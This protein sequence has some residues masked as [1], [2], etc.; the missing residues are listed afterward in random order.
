[1]TLTARQVVDLVFDEE[2]YVR[3]VSPNSLPENVEVKMITIPRFSFTAFRLSYASPIELSLCSKVSLL[4]GIPTQWYHEQ[5]SGLW[6]A[7]SKIG[8]RSLQKNTKKLTNDGYRSIYRRRPGKLNLRSHGVDKLSISERSTTTRSKSN[9]FEQVSNQDE[10]LSNATGKIKK[11]TSQGR[12]RIRKFLQKRSNTLAAI[13]SIASRESPISVE[14]VRRRR[15]MR[16]GHTVAFLP[17]NSTQ[18]STSQED[19]NT[20]RDSSQGMEELRRPTSELKVAEDSHEGKQQSCY[21]HEEIRSSN[22]PTNGE[23]SSGEDVS[24]SSGSDAAP[25]CDDSHSDNGSLESIQE[26]IPSSEARI[27]N[28]D[29][30]DYYNYSRLRSPQL[31]SSQSDSSQEVVTTDKTSTSETTPVYFGKSAVSESNAAKNP[32]VRFELQNHVAR[33]S[34][35]STDPHDNLL[36]SS[37]RKLPIV[38]LKTTSTSC[39]AEHMQILEPEPEP[40]QIE[41]YERDGHTRVLSTERRAVKIVSDVSGTALGKLRTGVA[42][43]LGIDYSVPTPLPKR[44][45]C[46]RIIMME[47]MLVMV[48]SAVNH[49]DPV[50]NF[51]VSES[52]D[53]RISERWKEYIVVARS[54]GRTDPPILLQFYHNRRIPKILKQD[55][56]KTAV[57]QNPLDFYIDKNCL[58]GLYSTLDKTIYIQKPDDKRYNIQDEGIDSYENNSGS[59]KIYILR[60]RTLCS[61]GKWH[62]FLQESLGM[63]TIPEKVSLRVPEADLSLNVTLAKDLIDELFSLEEKESENL[64]VCILPRGYRVFQYPLIRYITVAVFEELKRAGLMEVLKRWEKANIILGCDFKHYDMIQWCPGHRSNLLRGTYALF[65]SHLL[66][67]RPYVH[68]PREVTN[69]DGGTLVEP[70][71]VEG[72]LIRLTDRYGKEK[73]A[74][75]KYCLK[76]SYFF[77]SDN[78]LF[79]MAS[80]KATPPLPLEVLFDDATCR[81]DIEEAN[82]ILKSLPEVYEQDPYP[83]DLNS[84]IKWLNDKLGDSEFDSKDLYAFKCFNRRIVQILKS[85]GLLDMNLIKE[86]YQGKLTDTQGCEIKYQVFS[87]AK[88]TFWQMGNETIDDTAASV[89]FIVTISGLILK[90]LAPNPTVCKEWVF[91]LRQLV[92][93]WKAKQLADTQKMWHLKIQNLMNLKISEEEESNISENSPKWLTDRGVTNPTIYNVNAISVLRPL[94]HKGVLYQK[95]KRHATFSKYLVVLLPGFLMLYNCFNRSTTGFAKAVIDYNHY[96][97]IPIEDCYIYSGATTEPDLL[98]RD[99]TFD[100]LNPGSHTLPRAYSDGWRSTEDE[101]SRCFTLWFGKKRAM[102][103]K[104]RI[105]EVGLADA[106]N[107]SDNE[108]DEKNFEKNPNIIHMVSRLG[109]SGKSMVFMARSRQERDLWVLSIYYELERLNRN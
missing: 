22:F 12:R 89:I 108:R 31:R 64:K 99:R 65:K 59:L 75:R 2:K 7:I 67:Y 81:E 72:F 95:P 90:L 100:E 44:L 92:N 66:E 25:I 23:E 69:D 48:K 28:H 68:C 20:A 11:G 91:R 29:Y 24:Q 84:H 109:V 34:M 62:D 30:R 58:A 106:D 17:D 78:L 16:K 53:T 49:K 21:P 104:K 14:G 71:P 42:D 76:P 4:G 40:D 94:L 33:Y 96:L 93:Y 18:V 26:S 10:G 9:Q 79:F 36:N 73:N 85:E 39:T 103:L 32:S 70:Q 80:F 54:T 87:A 45:K 27:A 82:T 50:L 5:K 51:S 15:L 55:K 57:Y 46:G 47:K 105:D 98:K 13:P 102:Y 52:I 3:I 35:F 63:K 77:T 101:P 43:L 41:N 8:F 38:S 19:M 74:V 61:S 83:L 56:E 37:N 1:M 6:S 97:T 88:N 107:T 60:C 86:V